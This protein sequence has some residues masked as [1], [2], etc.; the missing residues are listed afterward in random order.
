MEKIK[1][2]RGIEPDFD[3]LQKNVYKLHDGGIAYK[4]GDIII[5]DLT[6]PIDTNKML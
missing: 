5:T 6:V 1:L 4:I 2:Y 3:F